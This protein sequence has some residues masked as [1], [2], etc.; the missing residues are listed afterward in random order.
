MPSPFPGMDPY[1][2]GYLWPDVHHRLATQISDQLMPMLRP[3]YVARLEIQ[4]IQDATSEAD[5][6]I[7]YPDVTSIAIL[8]PVNKR[9]PGLSTY[10]EKRRQLHAAEVHILE[11]DLLRRGQR[12]LA[13]P[14]TLRARIA[15]PSFVRQYGVQIS[16]PSTSKMPSPL[17][18]FLCARLMRI[19]PWTSL[20]L[21]LRFMTAPR[22][23]SR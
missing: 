12:P 21:S 18:R 22:M 1:L 10:R 2:E 19:F 23:T 9:E 17:Y 11:I 14:R 8:S 13:Y 6:G 5:I 20:P 7:M 4:V 16:G 3:R 15:L